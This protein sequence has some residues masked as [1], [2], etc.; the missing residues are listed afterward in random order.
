MLEKSRKLVPGFSRKW[1]MGKT[2]NRIDTLFIETTQIDTVGIYRNS[3][4]RNS[5]QNYRFGC[6]PRKKR[7]ACI[8]CVIIKIT[9]SYKQKLLAVMFGSV[10]ARA[11][12]GFLLMKN[13][14]TLLINIM[15]NN[16]M[17]HA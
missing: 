10:S 14:D 3:Y 7:S 16:K 15:V 5:Y 6:N 17:R 12:K 1:S 4:Q 8:V 11:G 2:Q 9:P 13:T